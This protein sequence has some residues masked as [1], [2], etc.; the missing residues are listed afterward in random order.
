MLEH[1]SNPA[2]ASCHRLM[3]PIGFGLESFDAVGRYR[4][5]ETILIESE[6]GK[7]K[8]DKKIDLNLDTTGEVAGIPSSS[9]SDARQLGTILS[10][11]KV[12]QECMVRQIF[13]YAYGRIETS[14]DEATIQQLFATFRD[15]GFHFRDLM[16]ALVKSPQFMAGFEDVPTSRNSKTMD[17]RASVKEPK[18]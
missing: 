18:Q 3:D 4:S 17:V 11:S 13:R 15:S 6:T 7:R 5:R 9:F 2:C 14:A 10:G 1:A 16:I 12:C 8:D